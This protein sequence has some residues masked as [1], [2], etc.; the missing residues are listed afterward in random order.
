M[1]NEHD[2]LVGEIGQ[3][4]KPGGQRGP[5]I[6]QRSLPPKAV[7]RI[8]LLQEDYGCGEVCAELREESHLNS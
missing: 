1:R 8:W 2:K 3:N 7:R 5:L 4:Q 6:K